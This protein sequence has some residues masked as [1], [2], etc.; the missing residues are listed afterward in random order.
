MSTV[1]IFQISFEIWGCI[2]SLIICTLLGSSPSQTDDP[3]SR[4]LRKLVLVNNLLLVTDS[5]AYI[6]RGN[7][8]IIGIAITRSCNFLLFAFEYLILFLVV[9]Y[10]RL[11]TTPQE[12]RRIFGWEIS[13]WLLLSAAFAGLAATPFTGFYYFFNDTNHYQRGPYIL[14]SFLL[15]AA[16][17][18]ICFLRLWKMRRLFSRHDIATFFFCILALCICIFM[19]FLF[20]GLSLISIGITIVFLLLYLRHYIKQYDLSVNKRILTAIHD[21]EVLCSAKAQKENQWEAAQKGGS[22]EANEK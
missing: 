15:C 20:Y 6:Y 3:I 12:S 13:S 21:T 9:R 4:L 14:V 18:L 10:I 8:R 5:L 11:L 1:E 16:V 2:I 22:D 17:I 19:Q 7:L